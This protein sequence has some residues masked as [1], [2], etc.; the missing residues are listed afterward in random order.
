MSAFLQLALGGGVEEELE[1]DLR[2]GVVGR[3][4]AHDCDSGQRRLEIDGV[5]GD[6]GLWHD[7]EDVF[8]GKV[9]LGLVE[10]DLMIIHHYNLVEDLLNV[11]HLMS[12]DDYEPVVGHGLGD[13]LAEMFDSELST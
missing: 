5:I 4:W 1:V 6:G 11:V 13:D 7:A 9:G 8:V 2:V 3:L 12:R 10:D